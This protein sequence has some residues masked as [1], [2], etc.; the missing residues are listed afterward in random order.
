MRVLCPVCPV[1][2][3]PHDH[4]PDMDARTITV[5]GQVRPYWDQTAWVA[6][7]SAA[8]LPAVSVPAGLTV[9]GLTV[10]LQVIASYLEDRTALDLGRRIEEVLGGF[11]AP[12][13]FASSV[14][15]PDQ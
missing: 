1:P 10:G 13:A 11:L 7:A 15:V 4:S 9:G 8:F 14:A 3:F 12:H 6:P 2:A 5:D